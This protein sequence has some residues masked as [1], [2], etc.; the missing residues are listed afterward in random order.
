MKACTGG[1]EDWLGIERQRGRQR[2]VRREG[3]LATARP[4]GRGRGQ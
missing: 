3:G 4:V 1:K 2:T